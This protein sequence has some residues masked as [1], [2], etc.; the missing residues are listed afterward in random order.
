MEPITTIRERCRKC[1]SCI[2]NC[3]VKAI[4]IKDDCAEVI[5]ERCIGCGKCI[6]SC[7]QSAKRITNNI[8]K[9][10]Q[11]LQGT[12]DVVAILGKR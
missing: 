5:S 7:S 11:L 9:V 6:K 3:P 4:K 2:R 1:Y 12:N 10:R 8:E